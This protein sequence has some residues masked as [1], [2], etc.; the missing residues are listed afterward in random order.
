MT[1]GALPADDHVHTEWS[2]DATDGSMERSCARAVELGLPSI[3]FTEH[4]DL[5]RWVIAPEAKAKLTRDAARVGADG[6]FRV[7]ALDV[8]GYLACLQR[9]RDRYP[10]LRILSG[11]E[12]GEPHWFAEQARAALAAG[13]LAPPFL[14]GSP[15]GEARP[16]VLCRVGGGPLP[17]G[18]R[19]AAWVVGLCRSGGRALPRG[20]SFAA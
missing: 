11:V 7:P 4:L 6:R 15:R 18:S 5:T 2:W 20:C 12:L 16:M 10:G 14:S 13:P 9:C 19:F 1:A 3:A 8:D 17:R